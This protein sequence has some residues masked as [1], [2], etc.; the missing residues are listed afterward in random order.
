MGRLHEEAGEEADLRYHG[1]RDGLV[2]RSEAA[3][4][5]MQA[6]QTGNAMTLSV[7]D[8]V[9]RLEKS[10]AETATLIATRNA[11]DVQKEAWGEAIMHDS[12]LQ[13]GADGATVSAYASGAPGAVIYFDLLGG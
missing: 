8:G 7:A 10:A 3:V 13:A 6:L 1:A 4:G 11:H 12:L 5:Q 2:A 9:H